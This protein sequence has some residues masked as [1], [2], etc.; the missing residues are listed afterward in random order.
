[1]NTDNADSKDLL[2]VTP[3]KLKRTHIALVVL[4]IATLA[5]LTSHVFAE[6]LGCSELRG[7]RIEMKNGKVI[8]GYVH[9][10]ASWF[11]EQWRNRF[12]QSLDRT[13]SPGRSE[14][15]FNHLYEAP[16]RPR[17]PDLIGSGL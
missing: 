6:C 8:T 1:M 11:T 3:G 5:V 12:P 15:R 14:N 10:N 2:L 16:S 7:V 13:R 4:S 17:E 9:W